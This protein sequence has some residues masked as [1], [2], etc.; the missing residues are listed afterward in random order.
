MGCFVGA[1]LALAGVPIT[2]VGRGPLVEAARQSGLRLREPE[3][4]RETGPLSA[5]TSLAAACRTDEYGLAIFTVK[6]Y[7]TEAIIAEM[8]AATNS[9]PPVL[10]LQNGVGN[11]ELLAHAFGPERVAAGALETPLSMPSPGVITAHRSRYRTGVASVGSRPL[12]DLAAGLLRRAGLVVD[13]YTDHRQL[14]WSKLLLNLPANAA[15]AILDWTPAQCISHPLIAPLE[16]RAWQEA[17][18][19][20]AALRIRPVNLAQLSPVPVG[21]DRAPAAG[22]PASPRDGADGRRRTRQQNAIIAR[23]TV[24]PEALGSG[25]VERSGGPGGRGSG[26]PNPGQHSSHRHPL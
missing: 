13:V 19:V 11:E 8:L 10:S 7:D 25:V 5:F 6:A 23:R 21:S 12:A 26:D 1:R 20:M 17:F 2:L 9:P 18:R 4:E 16:A 14:K 22:Q 15:C 3:G 24:C